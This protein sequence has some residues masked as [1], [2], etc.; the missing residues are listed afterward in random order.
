MAIKNE[1]PDFAARYLRGLAYVCQQYLGIDGIAH[2]H[3]VDHR[4]VLALGE[5][6][7]EPRFFQSAEALQHVLYHFVDAGVL[8]QYAVHIV[9][10]RV[11][12]VGK[13]YFLVALQRTVEHAG[14]LK[15]VKLLAYG[16]GA[17]AELC[18]QITQI[19]AGGG[20]QKKLD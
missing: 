18:F 14:L 16:I 19:G 4:T 7:Y 3:Q 2:E 17:F 5:V 6:A 1:V 10:E 8:E 11:T 15:A 12:G 20:V 13:E 9:E